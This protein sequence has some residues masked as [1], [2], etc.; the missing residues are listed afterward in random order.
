M[1]GRLAANEYLLGDGASDDVERI[2]YTIHGIFLGNID[3]IQRM[4]ILS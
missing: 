3:N 1:C 2:S 4:H